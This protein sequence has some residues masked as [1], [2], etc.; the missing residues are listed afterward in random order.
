MTK[1]IIEPFR[2]K[3]VEP[4]PRTTREQREHF[5]ADARYNPF[6][7]RADQITIDLLT[8]SGTGAMSTKQWAA[9]MTGDE[10][11]AG[12]LSYFDLKRVVQDISSMTHVFPVHQGRAAEHL[13]FRAMNITSGSMVLANAHFDTTRANVEYLG[14]EAVDLVIEDAYDPAS[15][16]PF[17]GNINLERLERYL[18]E[19]HERVALVLM[20]VTNNTG[21]GQ[22]VSLENLRAVS[23]IA[24]KF[25][26]PF[27]L[28]AARFAENAWFIKER[29]PRQHD[30]TAKDIAQEMFSLADG[31]TMSCKKDGLVNIGG[32]LCLNDD[33]LAE[34]VRCLLILM[35][36]YTTY[37][38]LAGRDM[39]AL[40]VGLEEVLD[41][42]YLE[43]RVASTRYFFNM[44]DH[45]GVPL[46]RPAGGHAVYIDARTMYPHIPATEFPGI[47]LANALYLEGG[48]RAVEVGTLMFGKQGPNGADIPAPL[49]LVRLTIP[50]R[51]YTQSHADYLGE[52]VQEVY[53]RRSEARGYR[54]V[55]QSAVLRAF[56]AEL[57]PV[58]T[59]A[60]SPTARACAGRT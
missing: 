22:P 27:F 6:L 35:E 16:H 56:T 17:K 36:G 42:Q 48:V 33:A 24:H 9:M 8:D 58:T 15:E 19:Q 34:K 30:R 28:D 32:L 40:A 49:D 13:L 31:F 50:R 5:L 53:E 59:P 39:A 54:V 47:A 37:G 14:A 60:Y 12:S 57:E 2:I 20:T 25:H 38:G 43:Y 26:K 18:R 1:T 4:L 29:E 46:M 23:E 10:T 21:G 3:M 44:L 52:I 11:Y 45:I 51:T 55:K 41:E 7:L